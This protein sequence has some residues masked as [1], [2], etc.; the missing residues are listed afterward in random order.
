MQAFSYIFKHKTTEES[1]FS[2]SYAHML[3]L[4]FAGLTRESIFS[5]SYAHTLTLSFVGLARESIKH[6]LDIRVKYE[7]DFLFLDSSLRFRMTII[8]DEYANRNKLR[9]TKNTRTQAFSYLFK[10]QIKRIDA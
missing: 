6:G 1:I 9:W 7:Y 3:T 10:H 5:S 8:F 2:S 4:S